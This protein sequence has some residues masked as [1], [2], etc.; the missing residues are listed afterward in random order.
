MQKAQFKQ[1]S[2]L[3]NSI[4]MKKIDQVTQGLGYMNEHLRE[5]VSKDNAL[6]I[7]NYIIAEKILGLGRIGSA[8]ARRAKGFDMPIIYHTR[9]GG[10]TN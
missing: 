5:K 8:V 10:N 1:K 4:L 2:S 3:D 9:H 7:A 6:V